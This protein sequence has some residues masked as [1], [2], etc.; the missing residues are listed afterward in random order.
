MNTRMYKIDKA[1]HILF[2]M[3]LRTHH[4][5]KVKKCIVLR[6]E[7]VLTLLCWLR[8]SWSVLAVEGT[9]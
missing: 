9:N 6:K 7:K 8:S 2:T 1:I 3:E 5:F 4:M